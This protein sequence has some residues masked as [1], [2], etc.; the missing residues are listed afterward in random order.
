MTPTK[1]SGFTLVELTITLAIIGLIAGGV[2][3]GQAFIQAGNLRA[4]TSDMTLYQRAILQFRNDF[5]GWPGDFAK[6]TTYWGTAGGTGS[7][8]TCYGLDK[9]AMKETCNGNGDSFIATVNPATAVNDALE[10]YL[11]WQHLANADLIG[12]SY[13]G[14]TANTGGYG[15]IAGVNTPVGRMPTS[16][17]V[18]RHLNNA[19]TTGAYC[20]TS[21]ATYYDGCYGLIMQVGNGRQPTNF[22]PGSSF[23]TGAEMSSIDKKIDDNMPG[24]GQIRAYK[25]RTNCTTSS[26][27]YN[28]SNTTKSCD[29][30]VGIEPIRPL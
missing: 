1:R 11:A 16:T 19:Y 5:G 24:F 20:P 12:G 30:I 17:F 29:M 13:T 3:A 6:A 25:A 2:M 23:I 28:L 15:T 10:P 22:N 7:D 27:L 18:M 9:S 21:D 4:L 8:A 26:T 14:K